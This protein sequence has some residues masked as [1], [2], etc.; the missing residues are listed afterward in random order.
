[1]SAPVPG[2][3]R[4][5]RMATVKAS[6]QRM[7]SAS[8]AG[9]ARDT[10]LSMAAVCR[11]VD[12]LRYHDQEVLAIPAH[13]NNWETR[14]GWTLHARI[15][16]ASQF[17]HNGTRIRRQAIR[18]ENIAAGCTNEHEATLYRNEARTMHT[19]ADNLLAMAEAMNP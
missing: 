9:I 14:L 1:M 17:R 2:G 13:G 8:Y 12:D 6:L 18:M 15:G 10:G 11:A 16:E 4:A 7:G 5:A 19:V 3:K